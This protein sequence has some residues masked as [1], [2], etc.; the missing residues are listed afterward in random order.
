MRIFY[1]ALVM[2]FLCSKTDANL[3]LWGILY[4]EFS[5]LEQSECPW[6]S[7]LKHVEK[8]LLEIVSHVL[9]L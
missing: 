7:S 5:E 8:I 1:I 3:A 6:T 2:F 4:N 9:I